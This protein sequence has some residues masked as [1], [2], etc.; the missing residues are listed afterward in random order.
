LPAKERDIQR[1]LDSKRFLS[2]NDGAE[3]GVGKKTHFE[4]PAFCDVSFA[5]RTPSS[6]IGRLRSMGDRKSAIYIKYIFVCC[7]M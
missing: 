1:W 4:F 7:R 3:S 6:H 5:S 2:R